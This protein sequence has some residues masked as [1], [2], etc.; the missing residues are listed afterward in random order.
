MLHG[1]EITDSVHRQMT[2]ERFPGHRTAPDR[3]KD[4]R[5][6][7]H[8]AENTLPTRSL[9]SVRLIG[10]FLSIISFQPPKPVFPAQAE[11]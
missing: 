3:F 1:R 6:P 10:I 7:P 5:L 8:A 11:G 2:R 4:T 9:L